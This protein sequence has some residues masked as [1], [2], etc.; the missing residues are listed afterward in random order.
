MH[1]VF[2]PEQYPSSTLKTYLMTAGRHS[3]LQITPL[4]EMEGPIDVMR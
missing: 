4:T 1:F 2:V 3:K